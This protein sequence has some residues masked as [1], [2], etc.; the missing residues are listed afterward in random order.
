M[1]HIS[2]A[3][4]ELLAASK[5]NA[6]QLALAGGLNA[7]TISRIRNGVQVWVSPQNLT[8]LAEAFAKQIGGGHYQRIHGQLVFARLQDE[9]VGPGAKNITIE[10]RSE[11]G[12][13]AAGAEAFNPKP[14]LPPK[15]QQN[16]DVIA[17]HI[18]ENRHIR[19]L[20][21]PIAN[22]C[23]SIPPSEGH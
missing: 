23:R 2:N 6:A 19:D 3:I 10:L 21:E 14:V 4:D 18:T 16:L 7:A 9:C 22:F 5:L 12:N 20:I 1:S 17:E 11:D 15:M 8:A 13:S